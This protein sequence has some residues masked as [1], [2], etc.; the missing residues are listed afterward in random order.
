MISRKDRAAQRACLALEAVLILSAGVAIF[1]PSLRSPALRIVVTVLFL[2]QA[3]VLTYRSWKAGQLAL[4]PRELFHG[5]RRTGP[6]RRSRLES[7]SIWIGFVAIVI[8]MWP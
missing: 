6:A 3:A 8:I 1:L 7:L 5:F 2:A 4:T